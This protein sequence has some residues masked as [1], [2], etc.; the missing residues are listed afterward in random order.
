MQLDHSNLNAPCGLYCGVCRIYQATQE[1]DLVYLK[2][3][4]KIYARQ[5]PQITTIS[6]EDLQCDGCLSARR[7]PSCRVCSIRDCVRLKGIEGCHAC[8][9]FPCKHVEE[10]PIPAGKMAISRA[11]PY[12]RAHGTQAWIR[13]ETERYQC[14]VCGERLYRGV[15]Q[16]P[17]CR[18]IVDL[19]GVSDW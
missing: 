13:S 19:D 18:S 2:R 8:A 16:C 7:F 9:D 11:V 17:A 6:A 5:F 14:P 12:R 10:F 3:L 15:K 1:D 4:G